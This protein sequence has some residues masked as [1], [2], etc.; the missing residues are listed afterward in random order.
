M[1]TVLGRLRYIALVSSEQ[2]IKN[3]K[4]R[5]EYQARWEALEIAK[6]QELASMTEQRAREMIRSLR[7]F[8]PAPVNPFNGL[9][10]VEQQ[11]IFHRRR[12]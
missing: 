5:A 10:L 7:L 3:Q 8:A 4:F 12:R 6:A 11:A 1:L 9:G 2:T